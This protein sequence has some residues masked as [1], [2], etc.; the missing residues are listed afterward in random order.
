MLGPAAQGQQERAWLAF[1]SW[2]REVLSELAYNRLLSCPALF[3]QA[4]KSYDRML[5]AEDVPL[6]QFRQTSVA[7]QRRFELLKPCLTAAWQLTS[8][9]QEVEPVE[10]RVPVPKPLFKALAVAWVWG[11]RRWAATTM[12]CFYGVGRIGGTLR[13]RREHLCLPSDLLE[14]SAAFLRLKK[15]KTADEYNTSK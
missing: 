3:A 2:L 13:R 7:A 5:F 4:L 15:P 10:H 8:R 11:W 14:E 1:N 9:W 12:L 6:Q